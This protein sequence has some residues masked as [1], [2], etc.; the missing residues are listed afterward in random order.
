M[1]S[2]SGSNLQAIIDAVAEKKINAEICAVLSNRPGA[3]AL[4]RAE[5]AGI[6][7]VLI[8]HKAYSDRESFD[9]AMIEALD[10]YEPD[11]VVLAGF[12]R[13]LSQNFC[14]HYLGRMINIHPALLPKYKGLNTHQRALDDGETFH[15][16]TVHFVTPELDDGPNILQ[17]KVAVLSTDNPESLQKRVL[18]QEHCIYPLAISWI[19][20]NRMKMV[21]N[22]AL[23]DGIPLEESGYAFE[24][25]DI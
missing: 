15:G 12:M 1:V 5:A 20:D 21:N 4:D 6:T 25:G 8:D 24:R 23:L 14:E 13:I 10:E 22:Q 2:G 16:C 9:Q 7:T 17:A 3:K 11:L 19:A 18:A